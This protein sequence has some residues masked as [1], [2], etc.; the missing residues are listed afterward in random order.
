MRRTGTQRE[1]DLRAARLA[2]RLATLVGD[3]RRGLPEPVFRL[4][5]SLTALVNVDL[6]VRD[7]RGRT[8][9]TWRDDG[10]WAPGWH[11]PGGIVRY[12]EAAADRVRAV[13]RLELGAEVAFRE[14]PLA[15]HEI[16]H[17]DWKQRGHFLSFLY[18]CRLATPADPARRYGGGAPR[19][20]QWAWHEGCPPDLLSAHDMYR[21]VL[22]RR[23]RSP[24]RPAGGRRRDP[25]V[26]QALFERGSAARRRTNRTP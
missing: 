19:H 8:L 1:R 7:R 10:L 23:R 24:G 9:L 21:G 4:V 5:S 14:P 26:V 25:L 16:I 20:G 6:L 17:P 18:A 13:A 3:P 2:A 15:V 11:V 22:D 12:K